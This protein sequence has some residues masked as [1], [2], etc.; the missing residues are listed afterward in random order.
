MGKSTLLTV[1]WTFDPGFPVSLHLSLLQ[2]SAEK[3]TIPTLYVI[4]TGRHCMPTADYYFSSTKPDPIVIPPCPEKNDTVLVQQ[5][6]PQDPI[7]E[8]PCPLRPGETRV[9]PSAIATNKTAVLDLTDTTVTYE[10]DLCTAFHSLNLCLLDTQRDMHGREK[11]INK[12]IGT[13]S[14]F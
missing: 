3:G 10:L 9:Y 6:Q 13:S 5:Q 12:Y 1:Q 2:T 7:P 8:D 14:H 11:A 4:Q